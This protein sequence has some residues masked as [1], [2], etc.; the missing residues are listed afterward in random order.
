MPLQC[1]SANISDIYS[2]SCPSH[3]WEAV[4]DFI[5]T[6]TN[7]LGPEY[8]AMI[9][10]VGNPAWVEVTGHGSQRRLIVQTLYPQL[11]GY[12]L[13][14]IIGTTQQSVVADVL[15]ETGQLW[16]D[17]VNNVSTSGHGS[18]I[19]QQDAV[20]TIKNDYYQPYTIASCAA[21]VIRGLSDNTAVAFPVPPGVQPDLMLN[22]TEY[23][24]SILDVDT[25]VYPGITKDEILKTLG[26]RE[27]S[28]LK[29][30]ELPQDPSMAL[31]SGL[32]SY[33]LGRP[34]IRRKTLL[35]V[36]SEPAGVLPQRTLRPLPVVL[37]SRRVLSIGLPSISM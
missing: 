5:Y 28:R 19:Q 36:V 7:S 11:R 29:W 20:H 31:Q 35:F 13:H 17:A 33:F 2:Y 3:G 6:S 37:H 8:L 32:L 18:L 1:L 30:V 9:K 22:K 10:L 12:D 34:K 14:P 27:G 24:D 26:S 16:T 21:D 25:F 23:N 15:T 4:Q